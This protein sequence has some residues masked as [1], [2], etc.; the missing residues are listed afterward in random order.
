[1]LSRWYLKSNVTTSTSCLRSLNGSML[2]LG[3]TEP[4]QRD[5]VL[6]HVDPTHFLQT[7]PNALPFTAIWTTV[8][9]L[10]STISH[11]STFSLHMSLEY[12]SS[13]LNSLLL[14]AY[15]IRRAGSEREPWV[16]TPRKSVQLTAV[17][18]T[19]PLEKLAKILFSEI[20]LS[21]IK[22]LTCWVPSVRAFVFN[23]N[24]GE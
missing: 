4:T 21:V 18:P 13:C 20:F 24:L 17:V 19:S 12:S 3:E 10:K 15:I 6:Y 11:I 16:H 14:H 1:M 7:S 23:P 5:R 22:E 8:S 9:S 2:L